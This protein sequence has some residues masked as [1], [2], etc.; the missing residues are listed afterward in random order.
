MKS[1]PEHWP[2]LPI[3]RGG[4]TRTPSTRACLHVIQ[5]W[6]FLLLYGY[7]YGQFSILKLLCDYKTVD[8]SK[9]IADKIIVHDAM[10]AHEAFYKS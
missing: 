2:K 8:Y 10:I 3:L 4:P 9:N 1:L 5:F 6:E 7:R